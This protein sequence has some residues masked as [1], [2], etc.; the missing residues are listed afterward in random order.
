MTATIMRSSSRVS[1]ST[2]TTYIRERGLK[3]WL[4]VAWSAMRWNMASAI[5]SKGKE[6]MVTNGNYVRTQTIFSVIGSIVVTVIFFVV[7]F[8]LSGPLPVRGVGG[9]AFDFVPQAFMTA[10]I[11][12]LIP[13]FVTR[14][15][16]RQGIL[17]PLA[18]DAPRP[19]SLLLRGL[20]F[21]LVSLVL[22]A[23]S[24]SLLLFV[25]DIQSIDWEIGLAVKI[26]FAGLVA[27]LVTPKAL[28]ASLREP[29]KQ[30]K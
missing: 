4:G 27:V 15:Q 8:D 13:G 2:C 18:G 9:Y 10:L 26:L 19:A 11:C 20:I 28:R 17:T 14:S 22:G 24:V 7:A 12:T 3:V 29:V 23:G 1:A 16:L 30:V 21:A 6:K 5:T 25:A